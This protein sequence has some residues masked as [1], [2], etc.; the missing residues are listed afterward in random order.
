VGRVFVLG[1]FLLAACDAAS[2]DSQLAADV[3]S[4][5]ESRGRRPDAESCVSDD[6]SPAPRTWT[7]KKGESL[8]RIAQRVY[9]DENLWKALRDANPGRVGKDGDVR[10]GVE[11]VVPYDGI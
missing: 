5:G 2:V 9:G 1:L 10:A 7:V 4:S 11:L 6:A 8:R 3:D